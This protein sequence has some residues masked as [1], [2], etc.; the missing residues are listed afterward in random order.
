MNVRMGESLKRHGAEVLMSEGITVTEA[1][2]GLF[3]VL[4][5]TR[6]VPECVRAACETSRKDEI[7]RKR[8]IVRSWV[9]IAP[10]VTADDAL[11]TRHERLLEKCAP[12]V[13]V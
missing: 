8:S 7:E 5:S 9:G 3:R 4:E 10:G 1:V 13:R 12:G 11:R 2:R 6:E